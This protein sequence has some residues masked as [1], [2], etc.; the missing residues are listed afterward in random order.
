MKITSLPF[1]FCSLLSFAWADSR[2]ECFSPSPACLRPQVHE[3]RDAIMKMRQ[4]DPGYVTFFGRHLQHRRNT[5]EVPRVWHSN[6][7]NCAV[8][9]DV[10]LPLATDSFRLQTLTR[11]G[12]E[13]ITACITQGNHCGGAMNV[14]PNKVM[15]LQVGYYGAIAPSWRTMR[16]LT[17]ISLPILPIAV[18]FTSNIEDEATASS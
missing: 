9:L 8:K 5:I 18:N 15:Q 2:P 7:K 6:P 4:T 17:N 13:I 14:G 3:C 11:Q 16:P 1:F 10:V 12:E